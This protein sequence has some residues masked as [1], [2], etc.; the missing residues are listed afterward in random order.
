[1]D[2]DF[3]SF[4][5]LCDVQ[6]PLTLRMWVSIDLAKHL[7]ILQRANT[8]SSFFF[9]FFDGKELLYRAEHY[10]NETSTLQSDCTQTTSLLHQSIKQRTNLFE[11]QQLQV[12]LYRHFLAIST[13]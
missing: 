10:L 6:L 3:Y 1:M 9:R 2:K 7:Y 8:L 12:L 4:A 5:R 13:S 11:K